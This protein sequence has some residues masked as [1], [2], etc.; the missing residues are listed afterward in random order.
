MHIAWVV[1]G[2]LDDRT[3]GTIYDAIVV[4]G[5]R[6]AGD[7][8]DVIGLSERGLRRGAA[9]AREIDT[10]APDVVVG[11]ELCF[12]EL[13]AAFT[14]GSRRATRVLLVH[15]LTAWETELARGA[16]L[17]ARVLETIAARAADA[18]VTTSATTAERLRR[19]TRRTSA[20]A[21]PGADR[22]PA[23]PRARGETTTLLFVGSIVP[24]KRALPLVR[25]FA[26]SADA[27]AE[28]VL[29]GSRTRDEAYASAVA[30]AIDELDLAPRVRLV[31]EQ[32]DAG[33]AA[34]LARADALVMPS[35]LEGFGIAAI[36]AVHAGAPVIAARTSG[37]VE[38]LAACGGAATFVDD[39]AGLA[40]ALAVF[41]RDAELRASMQAA[42]VGAKT[43]LPTWG[44]C[45][46][47]FRDALLRAHA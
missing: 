15:H 31:G 29:A 43:R 30:R 13:A 18:I 10:L 45:V 22:L 35:S 12:R 9:L 17:R 25:A 6:E 39:E 21:L 23:L 44:A 4:R 14:L 42:A 3:G 34:L 26:R 24:R 20:V 37:L 41:T 19:E 32:D 27:C 5:L 38:A 36:E 11:D 33:L 1:Y 47:A 40:H 2:G 7:R 28:L 46:A 8:V 16:R